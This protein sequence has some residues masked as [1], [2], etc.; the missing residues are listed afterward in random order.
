MFSR[1]LRLCRQGSLP[2]SLPLVLSGCFLGFFFPNSVSVELAEQSPLRESASGIHKLAIASP[3]ALETYVGLPDSSRGKLDKVGMEIRERLQQSGRFTVVTPDQ[4]RTALAASTAAAVRITN[5]H[6][7]PLWKD[8]VLHGARAVNADGV[9]LFH[10]K[11]ESGVS[12]GEASFGRKKY[13][14]QLGVSLLATGSGK[15][16][17]YQ[18]ATAVIR[19][20]I[21]LPQ[22]ED[23]REPLVH[24]LVLN[25]LQTIG[26]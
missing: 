24:Y 20:G 12:L 9:L 4:Y 26:R 6:P 25:F 17:W 11:W 15:V 5:Y 21:A 1:L 3:S 10:G 23:I 18:E 19:E 22:E 14:R 8:Y 13:K 16:V 2:G 7:D